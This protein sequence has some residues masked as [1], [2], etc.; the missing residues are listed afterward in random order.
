MM[1][2]P[3][4]F[5]IAVCIAA[6]LCLAGVKAAAQTPVAPGAHITRAGYN[7]QSTSPVLEIKGH[8]V[9]LDDLTSFSELV[10]ASERG[11]FYEQRD[12]AKEYILTELYDEIKTTVPV[13]AATVPET[14]SKY[15]L[16]SQR[17][18][19]KTQLQN[20]IREKTTVSETAMHS[21]YE[22]H[23]IEYQQ[24]EKVHAWHIFMG[25]GDTES[26]SPAKVRATLLQ[27][28]SE[29]EKGTSFGLL[30]K[31]NSEAES[32]KDGGEIG[33]ITRRMPIGPLQKPMNIE[34]EN[35]LFSLKSGQVSEPVETSYGLHLLYVSDHRTT[36]I[37][38][39]ETLKSRDV[40]ASAVSRENMTSDILKTI[41][42]SIQRHHG[43]VLATSATATNLTTDTKVYKF[44]GKMFTIGN[45]E[46]IYGQGFTN[47]IAGIK[48][49]PARFPSVM[50]Q[51]LKDEAFV[52]AAI[53][54]GIDQR[55]A[56]AA[57]LELLKKRVL[58]QETVQKILETNFSITDKQLQEAYESQKDAFRRPQ[59]EGVLISVDAGKSSVTAEQ[60]RMQEMARKKADTLRAKIKNETDF[61]KVAD[62]VRADTDPKTHVYVVEKHPI[63]QT[64]STAAKAFDVATSSLH[65]DGDI[66]PV[67]ADSA[68]GSVFAL[69]AHR[70]KGDPL[71]FEQVKPRLEAQAKF[72][73]KQTSKNDLVKQLEKE[74][75]VKFLPAA[76]VLLGPEETPGQ[77]E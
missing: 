66:S 35:A 56:V 20:E 58:E 30:A 1:K 2:S 43:K 26:S 38:D 46:S 67:T 71:P 65:N 27:I 61:K 4:S 40:I 63:G 22:Q 68:H 24:P 25:T 50:E 6:L 16:L 76:D 14:P 37:P 42:E 3:V 75:K 48:E 21:W 45:L 9:T 8:P 19:L 57:Y 32:G 11:A 64:T 55:P 49:T 31:K 15:S 53:D 60:A 34:L 23:K 28:K 10:Q 69:L 39:Y 70:Y 7:S 36:S 51:G 5:N 62:Q 29:A 54:A 74:G 52:Q 41:D 13:Q 12:L 72:R 59:T 33:E 44:D 77:L 47:A 73:I 17:N 18:Y